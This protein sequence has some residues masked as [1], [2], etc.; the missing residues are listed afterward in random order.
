MGNRAV[1]TTEENFNNNGIG[2]Y[3][4]WN[5]GRESVEGFLTYCAIFGHRA[6]TTDCYG[7][8]RL[9]Q[10]IA[11]FFGGS[12]SIGVDVVNSLD[13]DNY[14]NGVYLIDGWKI[15][16]RKYFDYEEKSIFDMDS[17]LGEFLKAIDESQPKSEQLG[18]STAEFEQR[19]REVMFN[20][21][22]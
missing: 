2:I 11:N 12:L 4:H 20:E 1:I 7:W 18:Y 5:G 21:N 10:V 16:G 17:E 9:T 19:A 8:A 15:I 6:P 22:D 3:V 14:D 13:C